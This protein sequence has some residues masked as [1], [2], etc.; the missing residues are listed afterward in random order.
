MEKVLI[1]INPIA[2]ARSK[3]RVPDVVRST[4]DKKRFVFETVFTE[5]PNTP[6][7]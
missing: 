1:I 2:G 5:G 3:V 7:N 4:L 6:K